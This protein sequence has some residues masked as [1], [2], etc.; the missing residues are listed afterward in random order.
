MGGEREVTRDVLKQSVVKLFTD[1]YPRPVG[2]R[3]GQL[4]LKLIGI[5]LIV[6]IHIDIEGQINRHFF[7]SI[8]DKFEQFWAIN[9]KLM[10]KTN[11]EGFRYIPF[12]I[13]QV[14]KTNDAN[15]T[16]PYCLSKVVVNDTILLTVYQLHQN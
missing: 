11:D 6:L 1:I 10:E 16:C 7:L 3:Y 8:L 4:E 12:R 14:R 9:R 5:V 2:F 13:Y 15:N